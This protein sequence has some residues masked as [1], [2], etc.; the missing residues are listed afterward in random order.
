MLAS[1]RVGVR[2]Q[3]LEGPTA[4]TGA[5]RGAGGGT[6]PLFCFHSPL[7]GNKSSK[8]MTPGK[9]Q[10]SVN[11]VVKEKAGHTLPPNDLSTRKPVSSLTV[12]K[13]L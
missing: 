5:P 9:L 13:L 10:S 1:P 3:C 8:E 4:T 7:G 6:S 2:T 11:S 12:L